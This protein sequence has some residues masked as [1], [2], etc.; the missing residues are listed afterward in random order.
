MAEAA[1][2]AGVEQ[3]GTTKERMSGPG[4]VWVCAAC[5]KSVVGDRY[6]L[7]DSA[8]VLH[9][10]LCK[11]TKG[12]ECDPPCDKV[13]WIAVDHDAINAQTTT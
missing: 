10:V 9:A 2:S 8:C 3:V 1:T 13:H 11:D 5:G 6:D 4:R 7:S 12:C